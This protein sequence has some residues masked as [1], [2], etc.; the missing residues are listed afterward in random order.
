METTIA[1]HGEHMGHA[2]RFSYHE[3][4]ESADVDVFSPCGKHYAFELGV[5]NPQTKRAP[6]RLSETIKA[7][8]NGAVNAA[9]N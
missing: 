9:N 2:Y 7:W 4:G 3:S 1:Y 5:I 8:I 6:M